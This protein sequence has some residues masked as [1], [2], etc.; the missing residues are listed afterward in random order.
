MNKCGNVN[1]C[2]SQLVPLTAGASTRGQGR[3]NGL[4]GWHVVQWCSGSIGLFMSFSM[5]WLRGCPFTHLQLL[6]WSSGSDVDHRLS[7]SDHGC[8]EQSKECHE[9]I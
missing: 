4:I 7:L 3:V 2:Y 8:H 9:Q 6:Q 1:W 5:L